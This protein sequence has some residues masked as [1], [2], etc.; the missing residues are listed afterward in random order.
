MRKAAT[1]EEV[2]KRYIGNLDGVGSWLLR[3]EVR[4]GHR[5]H[6]GI[7]IGCDDGK[8]DYKWR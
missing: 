4:K 7:V 6:E 3:K 8:Y 5:L 2:A 1:S